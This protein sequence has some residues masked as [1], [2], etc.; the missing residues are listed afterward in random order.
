MI[1]MIGIVVL[2]IGDK[3]SFNLSIYLN[4]NNA[5]LGSITAVTDNQ[6]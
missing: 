4:V 5:I 3:F 6:M 1:N 2:M